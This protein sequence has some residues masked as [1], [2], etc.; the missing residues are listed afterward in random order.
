MSLRALCWPPVCACDHV[1]AFNRALCRTFFGLIFTGDFARLSS[2]AT[3]VLRHM[4]WR[5]RTAFIVSKPCACRFRR[6]CA[7]GHA[8]DRLHR[9][10]DARSDR[11]ECAHPMQHAGA[12]DPSI[13]AFLRQVTRLAPS[14]GE[15]AE[16]SIA[17][18]VAAIES[19]MGA[20]GVQL[21]IVD[22]VENNGEADTEDQSQRQAPLPSGS[23]QDSP[24]PQWRAYSPEWI[25]RPRLSPMG[26]VT[27]CACHQGGGTCSDMTQEA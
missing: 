2:S 20:R 21:D 22:L 5:H 11:I 27:G 3:N 1:E 26:D 9:A 19:Q 17:S 16:R 15:E 10:L 13:G 7:V 14:E 8:E 23:P 24:N 12:H 18:R 4:S 25:L 6:R